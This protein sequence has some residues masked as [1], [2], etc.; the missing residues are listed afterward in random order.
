MSS[1]SFG[2]DR[3]RV[4]DYGTM[5][6]DRGRPRHTLPLVGKR[7]ERFPARFET[8]GNAFDDVAGLSVRY[9]T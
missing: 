9:S 3:Y 7:S 4:A 1:P 8:L 5:I 6:G 2:S